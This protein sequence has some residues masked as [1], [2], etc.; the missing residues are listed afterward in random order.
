MNVLSNHKFDNTK[1]K[2]MNPCNQAKCEPEQREKVN[3]SFAQMEQMCYCCGKTGHKSP[4]CRFRNK[5]KWAINMSQ[6]TNAQA[7]K[8]ASKTSK[9]MPVSNYNKLHKLIEKDGQNSIVNCINKRKW[10]LLKMNLQ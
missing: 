1:L 6:Q 2:T 4:Q 10:V 7:S 3:I 9:S 5:V 8:T